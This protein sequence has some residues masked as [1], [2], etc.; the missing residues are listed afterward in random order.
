MLAHERRQKR[1][2]PERAVAGH[3]ADNQLASVEVRELE[4]LFLGSLDF[5][6]DTLGAGQECLAGLSQRQVASAA[7][8]ESHPEL[9]FEQLD[10]LGQ[11][12]LGHIQLVGSSAKAADAGDVTQVLKLP[13][14]HGFPSQTL[15]R[16]GSSASRRASLKQFKPSNNK[17]NAR[18]EKMP[19]QGAVRR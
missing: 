2:Q 19:N 1:R 18:P 5:L 12:G 10:L 4:H 8:E 7:F 3:R 9:L 13:K 17:A 6:Q 15:L 16:R 11:G 14:L